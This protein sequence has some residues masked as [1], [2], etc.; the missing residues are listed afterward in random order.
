M[1]T[2]TA[3]SFNALR[4]AAYHQ[5][6]SMGLP[7]PKLEAW[8]YVDCGP[9]ATLPKDKSAAINES[10]DNARGIVVPVGKSSEPGMVI[11][12]G[13]WDPEASPPLPAGV[14]IRGIAGDS[15]NGDPLVESWARRIPHLSDISEAWSFADMRSGLECHIDAPV[16]QPLI[17]LNL[18]TDPSSAWRGRITVKQGASV[19]IL[20]IHLISPL[21]RSSVGLEVAVE[22]GGRLSIDEIEFS[23]QS[24]S[25]LGQLYVHKDI[26]VHADAE[27]E[28]HH[29]GRGGELVRHCWQVHLLEPG[30]RASLASGCQVRGNAQNHHYLKMNHRA[31]KTESNQLFKQVISEG[32]RASFDGLTKIFPGADDSHAAQLCRSLIL[33]DQGLMGGRPQLEVEADEVTATH[34]AA[35]ARP[36]GNELWYLR[37]RGLNQNEAMQLLIEGFLGEIAHSF[38]LAPARSLA[39]QQLALHLVTDNPA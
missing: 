39:S 5:A 25:L 4:N 17:I 21:A 32:G 23:S 8:R 38:S 37:S 15:V 3:V 14:T 10:Q 12:N 11:T 35:I 18:A 33:D 19:Q 6:I 2:S 29:A 9:L 27:T 13:T 7:T 31:P 36:D 22:A 20:L 26:S 34:G 28:W 24:Q 30:A 1:N 16:S